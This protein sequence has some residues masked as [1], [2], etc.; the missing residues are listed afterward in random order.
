MLATRMLQN[1]FVVNVPSGRRG[2]KPGTNTISVEK[3]EQIVELTKEG[4]NRPT[5]ARVV[6]VNKTT[7]WK[8]QKLYKLI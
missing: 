2:R 6:G 3:M 4:Y 8:Y 7:V 5:I 1:L